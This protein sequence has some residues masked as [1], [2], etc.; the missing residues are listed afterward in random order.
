MPV[1]IRFDH[2]IKAFAGVRVL[3]GVTLDIEPGELFFLLGP[4]GSGKTT[5][6][7]C[8]AGFQAPDAGR[9]RIG[10]E[11]VTG[12]PPHR[13]NTGMVFQNYA[14]WPHLTVRENVAFGLQVRRRP[15]AE[16]RNRTDE[17]LRRV[18]L[19]DRADARPAEL[20]GG[21]QQ[22]VALARALVVEPRC[23]L[24]D[25]PLSNLDARLRED[26]RDDIRRI[27]KEAG[28]TAV[29]VTH[30]Q[31]EAL[32]MADRIA[33]LNHGRVEQVGRPQ[34]IHE[35]PANRFVAGFVGET[36]FV[37]G[38]IAR[39]EGPRV[40]VQTAFGLWQA[41]APDGPVAPDSAVTLSLRP[42]RI[43][44]DTPPAAPAVNAWTGI[45]RRTV[46]LGELA[47]HE[48]GPQASGA[49][50]EAGPVLHVFEIRP[51]RPSDEPESVRLW[52]APEDVRVLD[53]TSS[54]TP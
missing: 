8:L 24:L 31:K 34:E 28:I 50:G 11:D 33:V 46:Y 45:L 36:N 29:Y 10:D 37:P 26:L 35:R 22:R 19:L 48:I 6:L 9:I 25:E 47:R 13:R 18:H 4:S 44:L 12:L 43:H 30:D 27:C 53:A 14:L 23:L 49:G 41:P 15:A 5:L 54:P 7:R 39:V 32:H 21:Q 20:S 42:E 2:I 17:A 1:R 52:I 51:R 38:R 40:W 3:D 16:I